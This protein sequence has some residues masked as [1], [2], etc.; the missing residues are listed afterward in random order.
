MPSIHTIT[1][2][3][4]PRGVRSTS[5]G[6]LIAPARWLLKLDGVN[7]DKEEGMRQ[8][9]LAAQNGRYLATAG[10]H[11][12]GDRISAGTQ[13]RRCAYA[14][15]AAS[16]GFPGQ[17]R[18]SEGAH[19]TG[20][21]LSPRSIFRASQGRVMG[22]DEKKVGAT[23]V[24]HPPR[25]EI[26]LRQISL[27][28]KTAPAR[29]GWDAP[30]SLASCGCAVRTGD[31]RRR[32]DCPRLR[33]KTIPCHLGHPKSSE[34]LVLAF[35]ACRLG[36]GRQ[37]HELLQERRVLADEKAVSDKRLDGGHGTSVLR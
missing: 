29:R 23:H 30:A 21:P 36:F 26:E 20:P 7:G 8:V 22:V 33:A 15:C 6:A 4:S 16:C 24:P 3:T 18:V 31:G 9:T 32:S 1:M 28:Q 27:N 13:G 19:S 12:V 10:P 25:E 14:A 11:S 17:H 5:S 35:A 37:V 34:W 2:R